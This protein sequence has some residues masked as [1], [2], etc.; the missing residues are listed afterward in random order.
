MIKFHKPSNPFKGIDPRTGAV[1][2]ELLLLVVSL[3]MLI[4]GII[5]T[6]SWAYLMKIGD[7]YTYMGLL[8]LTCLWS[9][10]A[11]IFS[12]KRS[13]KGVRIATIVLAVLT[14]C[15]L[16]VGFIHAML[17]Y[18]YYRPSMMSS[19]LQRQPAR[20]FMWSLGYDNVP[21]MVK[22]HQE[23]DSQW[24]RFAAWRMIT[25]G[26]MTL[27]T[28]LTLLAVQG[29]SRHLR[30]HLALRSSEDASM[31]PSYEK[32]NP[33][34][35][36]TDSM[37][38]DRY[39]DDVNQGLLESNHSEEEMTNV[40]PAYPQ[41]SNSLAIARDM[42][43]QRQKLY[44][45]IAK[46]RHARE[47][48]TRRSRAMNSR[49]QMSNG[50]VHPLDLT[51]PSENG[52]LN[53]AVMKDIEQG[54]IKG[55]VEDPS[56]SS[57]N[58]QYEDPAHQSYAVIGSQT[59]DHRDSFSAEKIEYDNYRANNAYNSVDLTDSPA[60]QPSQGIGH[61]KS[62]NE[63]NQ[64]QPQLNTSNTMLEEEEGNNDRDRLD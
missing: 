37:R 24:T 57:E 18:M 63:T 11:I 42:Y 46:R 9:V 5:F 30:P 31:D 29:Y 8:I 6:P 27:F 32:Q 58:N 48:S 47:G 51:S 22:L 50:S 54:E 44:A 33:E 14:G 62:Q 12:I 4:L 59:G 43:K 39:T 38:K 13:G 25:W 28:V 34:I 55:G 45:E 7:L 36:R 64:D 26:I 56:Y 41:D 40:P 60:G 49:R 10:V 61:N 20:L 3:L 19:C 2:A 16:V 23:C 1:G 52:S 15:Q 35:V 53:S 17:L 21:E